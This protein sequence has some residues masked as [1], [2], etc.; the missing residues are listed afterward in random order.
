MRISTDCILRVI[1]SLYDVSKADNHWFKTYHDHHTDKLRMTS[2]IYDSCLLYI[3]VISHIDMSIVGMQIDDILILADQSFVIIEEE[4]IHSVKI[5]TKTREQLSFEHFLKFNDI[6]IER[7][8]SN[9]SIRTT[10]STLD[11]KSTFKRYN[12]SKSSSLSSLVLVIKS[13]RC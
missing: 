9:E 7:I 5:M 3:I 2:F 4:A 13:K 1:K 10:L 12:W 6:R 8:D 11:K